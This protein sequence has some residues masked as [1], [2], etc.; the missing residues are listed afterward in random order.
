MLSHLNIGTG[1]EVTIHELAKLVKEVVGFQGDIVFDTSKLDGAPQKLLDVSR[2]VATGWQPQ[3][4]LRNGL[5]MT[6]QWF[7]E[8]RNE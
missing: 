6:Y 7:V 4:D 3:I 2:L 1:K 5:T 8:N